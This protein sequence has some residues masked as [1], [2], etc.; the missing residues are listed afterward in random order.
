MTDNVEILKA[1]AALWA[2][3]DAQAAIDT[4]IS[5]DVVQVQPESLP[6]GG[7]WHGHDGTAEMFAI[8]YADL[9]QEMEPMTYVGAGDTVVT[10]QKVTWRNRKTGASALVP[11]VEIATFADG[12]AV[13]FDV[14]LKDVHKLLSILG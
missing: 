5:P 14:Y 13:R 2:A 6:W 4:Y 11:R 1:M 9:D 10:Q 7:E 8:M 3:G 12:K